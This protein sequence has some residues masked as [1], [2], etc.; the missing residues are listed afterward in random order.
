M[1]RLHPSL[2][3]SARHEKSIRSSH[4]G[5]PAHVSDQQA[6]PQQKGELPPKRCLLTAQCTVTQ[7]H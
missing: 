5:S 4:D 3:V 6:A 2:G 7:G 1:R